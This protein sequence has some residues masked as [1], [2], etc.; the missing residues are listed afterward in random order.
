[1][2]TTFNIKILLFCLFT[3]LTVN[4][5]AQNASKIQKTRPARN[6]HPPRPARPIHPP[7]VKPIPS[8]IIYP[9]HRHYFPPYRHRVVYHFPH[10]PR[11]YYHHGHP[12]HFYNGYFWRPNRNRFIFSVPPFG[13]RINFLPTGY[14]KVFIGPDVY[15]YF[16][17]TFYKKYGEEYE[18][19]K[20]P[21]NAVVY[22]L[23]EEATEVYIGGKRFY[24]YNHVL[25]K[26]VRTPEGKVFKVVNYVN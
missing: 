14:H 22:E 18:V 3:I 17:G 8:H 1:M 9:N 23:P 19:I 4:M 26:V 20:A 15:F 25:Y 13:L 16:K 24:E 7:H 6:I 12:Y 10:R 21:Y 5:E 2:K 11:V